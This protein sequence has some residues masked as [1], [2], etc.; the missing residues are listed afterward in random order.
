MTATPD[1][2]IYS[3]DLPV[4]H[5][6]HTISLPAGSY[7]LWVGQEHKKPKCFMRAPRDSAEP[8]HERKIFVAH[9]TK[10]LSADCTSDTYV[11]TVI[12][13][14]DVPASLFGQSMALHVFDLGYDEPTGER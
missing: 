13:Q 9:T 5:G 4:E 8:K 7:P 6:E 11:G 3:F 10:P 12:L 2:A 1:H 14:G